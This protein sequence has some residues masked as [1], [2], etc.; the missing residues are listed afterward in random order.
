MLNLSCVQMD[1]LQNDVEGNLE[2]TE[3]ALR[4]AAKRGSVLVC[5][6]EM[7]T[8]GFDFKA[9]QARC[10]HQEKT[11]KTVCTLAK[12]YGVWVSGSMLLADQERPSNAHVLIDDQGVLVARYNKV[13]LFSLMKEQDYVAPGYEM[14]TVNAPWGKTGLSV[15]YDIRFPELFRHYALSGALMVC[16]PMAFPFPRD[17]HWKALVRARAIENQMFMVGVNQV[18]QE[19]FSSIGAGEVTYFGHSCIIDPWG[20]TVVQ[21][22]PGV[23]TILT[24]S[25]D[26]KKAEDVRHKMGVLQD[27][28]QDVYSQSYTAEE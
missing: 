17:A 1:V 24:A 21:A 3:L 28:R 25:I 26:L 15:C 22:G 19:D 9:N 11:L 6:P 27:R 2:K 20:E 5:F 23:E 18:G 4:E 12:Q 10:M 16:S 14:V 8:T 7:W 13:H